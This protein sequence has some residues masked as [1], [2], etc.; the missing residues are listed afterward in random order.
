MGFF[1]EFK[2]DLSQAVNELLPNESEDREENAE[3]LVNTMDAEEVASDEESD[4]E[5]M[6]EWLE[7]FAQEKMDDTEDMGETVS[8]T[9]FDPFLRIMRKFLRMRYWTS[10]L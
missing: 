2:D 9:A 7:E 6:K 3:Q 10:L 5:K 8:Q 1:K 4:T